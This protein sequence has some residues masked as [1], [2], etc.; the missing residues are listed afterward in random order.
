MYV[1]TCWCMCVCERV[2]VRACVYICTN[3]YMDV[4]MHACMHA[5]LCMYTCMHVSSRYAPV[6]Y[7]W[8]RGK[9]PA[10]SASQPNLRSARESL[11]MDRVLLQQTP[12]H[13]RLCQDKSASH[14]TTHLLPTSLKDC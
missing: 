8:A 11:A 6:W 1:F 7:L 4:C 13:L 5:C 3:I 12:E 10:S 14:P 9:A 2:C